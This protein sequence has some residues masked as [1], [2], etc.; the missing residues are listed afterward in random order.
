MYVIS[1]SLL[2]RDSRYRH[3]TEVP[4]PIEVNQRQCG[5]PAALY[6]MGKHIVLT[7]VIDA[8]APTRKL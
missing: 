2:R 7:E 4:K 8:G 6:E 3:P 5:L 1:L